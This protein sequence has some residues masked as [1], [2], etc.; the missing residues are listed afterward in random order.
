MNMILPLEMFKYTMKFKNKDL[1]DLFSKT[2]PELIY[3]WQK[4][5]S[6]CKSMSFLLACFG[7]LYTLCI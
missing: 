6:N 1:H 3:A 5:N 4:D 2:L 7:M